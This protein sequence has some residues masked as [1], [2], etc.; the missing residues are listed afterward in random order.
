MAYT[1]D[2]EAILYSDP[3]GTPV[4]ERTI[5]VDAD[6][7]GLGFAY[8]EEFSSLYTLLANT[9][10]AIALRPTTTNTLAYTQLNFGSGNAILRTPLLFGTTCYKATRTD[11][12]GA[13]GSAD[14]TIIPLFGVRVV[15]FDDAV[16]GGSDVIGNMFGGLAVR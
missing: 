11:Q 2:F 6:F 4:A 3:L 8:E 7:L 15:G 5:T 12:T 14:T 9:P 10:Y 13:F 1:D 16:G